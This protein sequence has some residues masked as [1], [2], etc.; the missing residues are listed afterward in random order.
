MFTSLHHK[1]YLMN[2]LINTLCA[3]QS[4]SWFGAVI[5]VS[6]K[7]YGQDIFHQFCL[8][9]LY[10][11][12]IR[13]IPGKLE[14]CVFWVSGLNSWLLMKHDWS[15]TIKQYMKLL[16]NMLPSRNKLREINTFNFF[17][18][19]RNIYHNPCFCVSGRNIQTYNWLNLKLPIRD[20]RF[21]SDVVALL[22]H[23][24]I[25]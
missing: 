23:K 20:M 10:I 21:S 2:V 15:R 11:C 3:M 8:S 5:R 9:R 6:W 16:Y 24:N 25:Y 22:L 17:S 19:R 7:F 14:P 18:M 12:G 13:A 4:R 1:T